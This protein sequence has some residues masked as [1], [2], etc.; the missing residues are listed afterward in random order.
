MTHVSVIPFSD[1]QDSDWDAFCAEA[2]NATFLHTRRFL[3]YHG[4]CFEDASVWVLYKDQVVGVMPAARQPTESTI[5]CSHPGITY[6]GLVTT[7]SLTGARFLMALEAVA[8]HYAKRGF[9]RLLYKV[10]PHI[11]HRRPAQDDLYALH[12]MG[13]RRYRTDLAAVIDLVDRGTPSS[14]RARGLK[15][16]QNAG[17]IV[18]VGATYLNDFWKVL[19]ENL[20]DRYGVRPVH[21]R[22]ELAMLMARFPKNISL[23]VA[24]EANNV[25]AGVVL[26]DSARVRH[27]QYIGAAGAGRKLG[28]LDAV[29]DRCIHEACQ[30]GL[31]F[32]SFGI[33][34]EAEGKILNEGL[35]TFKTEFGASGVVH[36][37]YE[38]SL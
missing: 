32:F 37:F 25:L 7:E 35:Y 15:K 29:L 9:T 28:A 14:R 11:Y 31:R 2:V 4:S 23:R 8:Q 33:S 21:S 26:F 24:L 20:T 6:G 1:G 38:L 27:C 30:Y 36:E 12:R 17:V 34:T 5:V 18:D 13:A 19:E 3:S 10:V 22:A 16:A